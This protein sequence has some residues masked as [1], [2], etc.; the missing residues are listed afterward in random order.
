[1]KV[2]FSKFNG[3]YRIHRCFFYRL[4]KMP[5]RHQYISMNVQGVKLL[6]VNVIWGSVL[7][8]TKSL[9][10]CKSMDSG[11]VAHELPSLVS[12]K[13]NVRLGQGEYWRALIMLPYNVASKRP[14]CWNK[15]CP[16]RPSVAASLDSGMLVWVKRSCMY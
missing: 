11:G 14:S 4:D 1:M 16:N 7:Y 8:V 10:Y 9:F 6:H 13:W 2:I 15:V 5:N 3:I 12:S